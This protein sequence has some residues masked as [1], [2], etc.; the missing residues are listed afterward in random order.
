LG[1]A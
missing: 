1:V